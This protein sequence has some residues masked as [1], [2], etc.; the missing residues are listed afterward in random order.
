MLNYF[1][2]AALYGS[3]ETQSTMTSVLGKS[4]ETQ[5]SWRWITL[6]WASLLLVEKLR[7][8]K[9]AL[10][11][12]VSLYNMQIQG[13]LVLHSTAVALRCFKVTE[14]IVSSHST[15][16]LSNTFI[17]PMHWFWGYN[18][19]FCWSPED[20]C[21]FCSALSGVGASPGGLWVSLCFSN[22]FSMFRCQVWALATP[23]TAG[24][25]GWA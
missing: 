24:G 17:H 14:V 12:S 21:P 1:L 16:S 10:D 8:Q 15:R 23:S 6:F 2:R 9:C 3:K 25:E 5:N 18:K 11:K 20:F 19:L 4:P 7:G 22:S 13:T